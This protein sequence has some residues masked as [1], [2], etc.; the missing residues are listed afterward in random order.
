MDVRDALHRLALQ[1]RCYGS[2]RLT[3][4][5]KRE[6]FLVNRKRVQRLVREDS[7]LAVRRRRFV[8]ATTDSSHALAVYPNLARRMQLTA[9]NQLR[10]ADITFIRLQ[11]EFVYLAVILD[12]FSRRV[13]G[14]NL[15]RTL[16]ARLPVRAL[17]RALASRP[18][19]LGLVH[20]S[21]RGVQ[22]ASR[23]YVELL[24]HHGILACS[25]SR[26][27]QSLLT[28]PGARAS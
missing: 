13:I 21:D 24:T 19:E 10:V 3:A 9:V 7:L 26:P 14:W 25:M 4:M 5:L 23:E 2:R 6:G 1:H 22:Y 16:Q 11:Q 18:V 15:H 28:T 12:A 20:H 8:V 17:E 27:G